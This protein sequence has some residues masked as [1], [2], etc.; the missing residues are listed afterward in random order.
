MDLIIVLSIIILC[1]TLGFTIGYY[2]KQDTSYTNGYN[3]GI[4]D[5]STYIDNLRKQH[6]HQTTNVMELYEPKIRHLN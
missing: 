6:K 3:T 4:F 2:I 5:C 1:F